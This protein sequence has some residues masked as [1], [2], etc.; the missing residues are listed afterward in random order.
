MG[1]GYFSM[2]RTA[3][4][5]GGVRPADGGRAG[6]RAAAST[7]WPRCWATPTAC[8]PTCTRSAWDS[9][10]PSAGPTSSRGT[11]RT[12]WSPACSAPRPGRPSGRSRPPSARRRRSRRPSRRPWPASSRR[13]RPSYPDSAA[14]S[15]QGN[16][17]ADWA[18]SQI[19]RPY[20]WGGAG[21][22]T[23]D[24]SGLTM[25]AW[26]HA[27][28]ALLHYTGDQRVEGVHVSLGALQR[29]DLLFYATNNADPA[30]FTTSASTVDRVVPAGCLRREQPAVVRVPHTRGD[31]VAG[32]P[33]QVVRH[34]QKAALRGLRASSFAAISAPDCPR[35]APQRLLVRSLNRASTRSPASGTASSIGRPVRGSAGRPKR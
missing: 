22:Y 16:I 2:R 17:A 34:F 14:S 33:P 32:W 7:P 1:R 8:R 6:V 26:S 24:C 23:Y 28:V 15:Q 30:P 4:G 9:C 31:P 29:G 10:S 12:A 13:S 21:P 18:L 35:T 19:G 27:G 5:S 11:A 3:W 20:Q 25:V